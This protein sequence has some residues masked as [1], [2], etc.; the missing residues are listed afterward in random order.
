MVNKIKFINSKKD[1][2]ND[3]CYIS[4][5]QFTINDYNFKN[6][7]QLDCKHCFKYNYFIYSY[8]TLKYSNE[9]I[10]CPYCR[11]YISNIPFIINTKNI[12]LN[13]S[14]LNIYIKV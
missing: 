11:A 5:E 10:Y 7:I 14:Q 1:I 12:C 8:F 6:I 13:N 4:G 2:H 9:H 3:T